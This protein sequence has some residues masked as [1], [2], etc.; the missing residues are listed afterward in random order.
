MSES[1][2]E[3]E[4]ED[5]S[6]F[7][8][9]KYLEEVF[10]AKFLSFLFI[11]KVLSTRATRKNCRKIRNGNFLVEAESWSQIESI[12]KMIIFHTTKCRSYS[13]EKFYISKGVIRS[14]KLALATEEML[15]AVGKQGVTNINE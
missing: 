10:L 9:I 8:V 3:G 7:I 5:Y 4:A 15:A 11:K 2:S 13:H 14:R 1:D 12:L 6:R